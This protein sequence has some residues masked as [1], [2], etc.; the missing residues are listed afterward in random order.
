M[1][2]FYLKIEPH[3]IEKL[4]HII[5]LLIDIEIDYRKCLLSSGIKS[6]SGRLIYSENEIGLLNYCSTYEIEFARNRI[7]E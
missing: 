7:I 1:F 2:L 6:W 5:K 3:T 4:C